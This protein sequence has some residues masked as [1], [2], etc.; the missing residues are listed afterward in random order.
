MLNE[1]LPRETVEDNI[2]IATAMRKMDY[3]VRNR[4]IED[5]EN[6][7]DLRGREFPHTPIMVGDV[8]FRNVTPRSVSHQPEDLPRDFFYSDSDDCA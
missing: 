7:I 4:S 6:V 8:V 1:N 5:C 2:A 3:L